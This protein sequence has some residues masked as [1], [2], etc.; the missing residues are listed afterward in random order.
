MAVVCA[1]G[2]FGIIGQYLVIL[3]TK[4]Y[5]CIPRAVSVPRNYKTLLAKPDPKVSIISTYVFRFLTTLF[6]KRK[7]TYME[8]YT[9]GQRKPCNLLKAKRTHGS[10]L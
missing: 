9:L 7:I 8:D 2:H 10:H 5:L 6:L 1:H 4:Y 3:R